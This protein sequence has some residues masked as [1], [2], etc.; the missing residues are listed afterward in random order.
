MLPG[1]KG[2][3]PGRK[4][5]LTARKSLLPGC[6]G[7]LPGG[8]GRLWRYVALGSA[9]AAMLAGLVIP[10]AADAW[11][12]YAA[13]LGSSALIPFDTGTGAAGSP[14]S[15]PK[16][17]RGI[18]I[19]P[20]AKTAWVIARQPDRVIPVRLPG[21]SQGTPV[22]V[23][24]Q[25]DAIAITPDGSRAYV[26]AIN[27]GRIYPIDLT[28]GT[29]LD[30][31]K[32]GSQ[33]W[34][35]AISPDGDSAWL[36]T[37]AN[38]TPGSYSGVARLDLASGAVTKVGETD[39]SMGGIAIR[40]DGAFVYA[41]TVGSN[42]VSIVDTATGGIVKTISGGFQPVDIAITPDGTRGYVTNF[43]H[44]KVTVLDLTTNT[45]IGQVTAGGKYPFRL[46]VSP[47]SS[48]VWVANKAT[49]D[50]V[51]IDVATGVAGEPVPMGGEPDSIVITPD[52]PPAAALTAKPEV[53][54]LGAS[55]ELD[56]SG[57][58]PTDLPIKGEYVWDF[59]DGASMVTTGPTAGHTY[60]ELGN[61]RATVTLSDA[62]GCS[63]TPVFTGR[64]TSCGGGESARAAQTVTVVEPKPPGPCELDPTL[65]ECQPVVGTARLG[66][67]KV[68]PKVRKAKRNR[69]AIFTVKARNT[70]D[71]AATGL[72]L[73][74]KAPKRLVKVRR[75]TK[76]RGLAAGGTAT[77]KVKAKLKRKAR[78]GRV[79]KLRF[80]ATA[81]GLAARSGAGRIRV[82]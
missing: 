75:C 72:R 8:K 13:R 26:A 4:R 14:I 57:S 31:I 70:G 56:A 67:L 54:E 60:A 46:A 58:T 76:P 55:V 35:I 51:P 17:P 24:Q 45:T 38:A 65:P 2:L 21:G 50:I 41:I 78:R 6:E 25:V 39:I 59:G 29:G 47:D 19:A 62:L 28:T 32:V 34:S 15:L 9:L 69:R 74:I 18:A 68:K 36:T 37:G 10:A 43:S 66:A 80:R 5:L 63:M 22:P 30:P 52:R 1:R 81:Q 53:V 61:Y 64:T 49:A 42:N 73:C 27:S 40:P 44:D 82:R 16:D 7:L 77:F 3:L 20:D 79:V 33:V 11:T 71:A 12:G 23:A 48:K